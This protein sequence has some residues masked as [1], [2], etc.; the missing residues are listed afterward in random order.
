M[1]FFDIA[2]PGASE[3]SQFITTDK[4]EPAV[5][6]DLGTT[7]SLI[8][9]SDNQ[10]VTIFKNNHGSKITPS[11]IAFDKSV[12]V[13]QDAINSSSKKVSSFKR[14]LAKTPSDKYFTKNRVDFEIAQG[15]SGNLTIITE[16]FQT[17]P[18]EASAEIL[19]S[20]KQTAEQ[21]LGRAIS[22][23]V[24][25]VPAYFDE[26]ARE[27]TRAAA[28]IAGLEVLRLLNEPTAAAVA[29][30]LTNQEGGTYAIYDLGGGTFDV[31][32]L[33][34]LDG[35]LQVMATGGDET[36][37]GDDFDSLLREHLLVNFSGLNSASLSELNAISRNLKEQLSSAEVA[38]LN[39]HD[40]QITI[41][42]SEFEDLIT[43][44]V[45]RTLSIF[46]DV[47]RQAEI[48]FNELDQIILV[49]GSSRIPLIFKK[50]EKLCGKAPLNHINPDEIVVHGAAIQAEAL[51]K[52]S[53]QL[54]LDVVALSLG[55]ELADG[56]VE[57]IISRNTPIPV[58]RTMQYTT[59]QDGQ[60]GIVIHILQGESELAKECRSISRFELKGIPS[61]A[62]GEARIE[63][64][65]QLD[66]D[67]ILTVMAKELTT[68]ITQEV[69][70][71][72]SHGL[73][74]DE[75]LKL[76]SRS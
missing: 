3:D 23:A 16:K 70:A 30:S 76:I 43:P 13:G 35:V 11:V 63:V 58:H 48:K 25:T 57:H 46:K 66:A 40:L 15:S 47:I 6:I 61:L 38:N 68:N 75:I 72:P 39:H 52:G 60:T 51:V 22:K 2:E 50:L 71:R 9:I 29:Y 55:I 14:F 10:Q 36:L 12:L 56:T 53:S 28:R 8:A 17:T 65:F 42:R 37:G 19:K 73:S 67:G 69:I 20:L 44:L 45:D 4:H 34:M 27:A 24:I 5:G 21:E 62:K 33:K 7:N 32:I 26:S 41:S 31:S 59:G 74:E 18:I 64:S 54:L 1:R 49:G